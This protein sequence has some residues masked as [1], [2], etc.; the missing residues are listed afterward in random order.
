MTKSTKIIAALGV[1]AGLGIAALPSGAIFA[2]M[3]W[4]LVYGTDTADGKDVTV[5]LEVGESLALGVSTNECKGDSD[6]ATEGIQNFG[7]SDEGQCVMQIAGATNAAHGFDLKVQKKTGA[8]TFL[9]LGGNASVTEDSAKVAAVNGTAVDAAHP[10]WNLTGGALTNFGD[11]DTLTTIM[12]TT[13]AAQAK[14][15]VTYKFATRA[16]QQAGTYS[17]QLTY[18]IAKNEPSYDQSDT[19]HTTPIWD[20]IEEAGVNHASGYYIVSNN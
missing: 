18:T 1:A 3:H 5:K 13:V 16:D 8:T 11:F 12:R 19:E 6:S 15:D 4:P 14:N 2:D 10:G 20:G 7:I 9:A 17:T